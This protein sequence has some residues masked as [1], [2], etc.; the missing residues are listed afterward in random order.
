M[1]YSAFTGKWI[2]NL[3]PPLLFNRVVTKRISKDFKEVDVVIKKSWINKNLQGSIFGGTLF[4]AADPFYA[5]MYWNIFAHRKV[6]MEAWVR[7]IEGDYSKPSN[8]NM[9]LQFRITD[10]EILEAEQSVER[11]GKF[12]KFHTIELKNEQ[13][14][15]CVSFKILVIIRKAIKEEKGVF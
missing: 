15:V 14:E 2:M 6:K 3:Y 5:M 11:D 9:Y 7:H 10:A 1:A 4:S 8:T 12:K 13:G